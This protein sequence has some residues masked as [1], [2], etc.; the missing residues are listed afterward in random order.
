M[1]IQHVREAAERY[2][3]HM[4]IN[5]NYLQIT[6]S[7]IHVR[8]NNSHGKNS[9]QSIDIHKAHTKN[10]IKDYVRK[11]KQN[12][13][14]QITTALNKKKKKKICSQKY[15]KVLQINELKKM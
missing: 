5:E 12:Q 4:Y 10:P 11:K 6:H 8:I 9:Y 13:R 1:Y 15:M 14:N 2:M 3:Q 7:N